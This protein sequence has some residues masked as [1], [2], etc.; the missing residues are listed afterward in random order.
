MP[1]YKGMGAAVMLWDFF[2][3]DFLSKYKVKITALF[4]P[5]A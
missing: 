5:G 1:D 4:R 2:M 3:W